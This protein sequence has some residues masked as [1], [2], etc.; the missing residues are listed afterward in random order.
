MTGVWSDAAESP[1]T[2]SISGRHAR[3]AR[4]AA[5]S[6]GRV[7]TPDSASLTPPTDCE[8]KGYR[9]QASEGEMWPSWKQNINAAGARIER[10]K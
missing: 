7:R 2:R 6:H 10:K 4:D 8:V 9:G 1:T 3:G 5:L